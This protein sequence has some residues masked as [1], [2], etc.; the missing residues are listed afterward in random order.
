V[1]NSISK[2]EILEHRHLTQKRDLERVISDRLVD[3]RTRQAAQR[4]LFILEGLI[5]LCSEARAEG[6]CCYEDAI[7]IISELN[8]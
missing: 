8:M 6:V 1:I 7:S 2:K 4:T 5:K 3:E